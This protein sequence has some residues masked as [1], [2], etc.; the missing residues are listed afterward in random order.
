MALSD[1]F[2]ITEFKNEISKLSKEVDESKKKILDLT[3]DRDELSDDNE[4]LQSK[5]HSLEFDNEKLQDKLHTL[6]SDNADLKQQAELKLSLTQ[7]KPIELA[8]QI[9]NKET[10]LAE[11]NKNFNDSN[12]KYSKLLAEI[13]VKQQDLY[14]LDAQVGDLEARNDMAGYGLPEP[15]YDFATSTEYKDKLDEIRM[16]QKVDIQSGDAYECNTNWTIDG[17]VSKGERMIKRDVKALFRSFNNECTTAINKVTYSN[18][19]RISTRIKKSFEQHNKM[20]QEYGL[21]IL[22]SYLDLKLQELDLAFNYA[23][24]KEEEKELL[25][26]QRAREKEEKALQREIQQERKNV[27]KEIDHYDRAINELTDK[28]SNSAE[29]ND[30]LQAEIKQLQAKL[31]ELHGKKAEIDYRDSN[32]T[33]GYVYIISNI[34]SFGKDVVKIGVTRRLEPLDRINE[35]SS[36]SVPFKFDVH[37]LIFSEDAYALEAKLHKRFDKNRINKVN[38]RKEYFKIPIQ[39][40]EKELIKYKDVTVDFHEVPDA[41]EYRETIAIEHQVIDDN[42]RDEKSSL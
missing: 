10:Q 40:I 17:S 12:E 14:E 2:K 9:K 24:K 32:A 5:Y 1:M 31:D 28:L 38:N 16:D 15:L 21:H 7:M 8:N 27:N 22:D 34:G 37:A 20:H 25:R 41:P 29:N 11:L 36:A 30:S 26:E 35:L 6:K 18:Y 4:E 19:D 33:A 13:S 3:S 42:L 39:T 23:K